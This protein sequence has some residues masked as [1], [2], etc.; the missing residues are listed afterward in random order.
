MA[1]LNIR[2]DKEFSINVLVRESDKHSKLTHLTFT[3]VSNAEEPRRCDEM[4]LTPIQMELIGR[5][6]L[7]E[8]DYINVLQANREK[9]S[10]R[11]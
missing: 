6:L 7:R 2:V 10:T 5:F 11:D 4:F 8:A 3:S 1:T 9:E